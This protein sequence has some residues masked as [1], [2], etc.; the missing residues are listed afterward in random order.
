MAQPT[1]C[2]HS[3]FGLHCCLLFLLASQE[4]GAI[5]FQEL[6][7]TGDSPASDHLFPPTSGFV[8]NAPSDHTA[9]QSGYS[10]LDLTKSTEAHKLKHNCNTTHHLKPIYRPVDNSQ[11]STS[12]HEIPPTSEKN[13]S[14]QGRDPNVRNGRSIDPTD[15]TN[16]HK[17]L[18]GVKHVTSAAKNKTT[19]HTSK[20]VRGTD[21]TVTSLGYITS[22]S[23]STSS[24]KRTN[25]VYNSGTTSAPEGPKDHGEKNTTVHGKTTSAPEGSKDH[26]E[27][28][29]TVHGKTTSAPEVPTGHGEKTIPANSNTTRAQGGPKEH[30]ENVT[31]VNEKTTRTPAKSTKYGV[32]ATS[33]TE[34]TNPP[35]NP[36]ES[37]G[38]NTATTATIRPP[39][40]VTGGK[41]VTNTSPG[42]NKTD[43]T[44][45]VP[46][47][48]F[49]L[50]TSHME[51]S[52]IMSEAPGNQ[53]HPYQNK[54]GSQRGLHA[55][56][57][58]ENDSFPA[59]AIVIVVLVAVILFL[60]FLGLIFLIT[61]M[62]KTRG[63]LI[64]N[65]EDNG[66]EDDG[67][68]NSYPVYLMEQQT[69]G[70][71]QIP[72]PR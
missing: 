65:R 24:P 42:S 71:G 53:N 33:A 22:E 31:P 44:H 35:R 36:G 67:S 26:G 27:K 45:E 54:D 21:K 25:P 51:P 69:L 29:T 4:A 66:P 34:T 70:K 3:T 18:S 52:S 40:N 48:S 59:W 16:I 61:Y 13:P 47:G 10:P 39:F 43:V 23:K 28:N 60:V 15:S 20:S 62:M 37:T 58:R 12:H 30:G 9:L 1:H 19:C 50:S 63:A 5:T 17:G 46:I 56:G 14:N 57:M 55:G 32:K 72:S 8:Y 6:W 11:N 41:S 38:K 2:I 68:P 49:T 64:Q 7:N